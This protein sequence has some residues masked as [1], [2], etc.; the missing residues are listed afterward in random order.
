[1]IRIIINKICKWLK[2]TIRVQKKF[3]GKINK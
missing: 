2:K 3:L 1:V